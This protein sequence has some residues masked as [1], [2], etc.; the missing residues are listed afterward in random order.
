VD[1]SRGNWKPRHKNQQQRIDSMT[2]VNPKH[3]HGIGVWGNPR[4]VWSVRV[5]KKLALAFTKAVKPIFGSTCKAIE[6]YMVSFLACVN[7]QDQ[8]GVYPSITMDINIGKIER[9]LVRERR[10]IHTKTETV[11]TVETVEMEPVDNAA[12][13]MD[14]KFGMVLDQ[15]NLERV[16]K[17][18]WRNYWL[19]EAEK[20]K[21]RCPNAELILRST[22]KND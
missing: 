18:K 21:E 7:S 4:D 15:W 22:S 3:T 14:K 17:A 12:V 5:D 19:F 11:E 10:H 8:L 13:A 1:M 20:W 6:T 16:N 9:N 2:G